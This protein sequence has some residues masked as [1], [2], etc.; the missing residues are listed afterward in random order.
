MI[1]LLLAFILMVLALVL[2]VQNRTEVT[3]TFLFGY[4]MGPFPLY[5]VLFTA[6]LCGAAATL[7]FTLPPWVRNKVEIRRLRKSLQKMEENDR[8][9]DA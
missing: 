3:L 7:L 4:T 5:L 6:F 9:T 2:V 1:R 8:R